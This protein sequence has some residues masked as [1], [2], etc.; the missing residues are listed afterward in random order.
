MLDTK[1][2][3]RRKTGVTLPLKAPE[4]LIGPN[5]A[6]HYELRKP[7]DLWTIGLTLYDMTFGTAS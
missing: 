1:E 6:P 2:N 3:W 5:E 7:A 4:M